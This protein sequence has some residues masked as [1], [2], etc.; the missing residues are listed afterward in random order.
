MADC[1]AKSREIRQKLKLRALD[2]PDL[3]PVWQEG[4]A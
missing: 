3:K 1:H 4:A 2:E